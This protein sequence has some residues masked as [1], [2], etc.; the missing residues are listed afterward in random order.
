MA[1]TSL[2]ENLLEIGRRVLSEQDLDQVLSVA[3]DGAIEIS[4]AERGIILLFDHSGKIRFQTARN[5]EKEE[6]NQP[7]YEISRT[8]INKVRAEKTPLYLK[9]AREDPEFQASQS[10]IKLKILSVICLPLMHEGHVFGEVYLDNRTVRGAFKPESFLFAQKFADFISVAAHHALERLQLDS[11]VHALQKELREKFHFEAV[12]GTHP[13]IVEILDLIAQIADTDAT[14]LLQGE[15]GTGKELIA[16][17]LHT[18]SRRCNKPFVPINCGALPENLLESELFGHVRGAFTGATE[19]KSGWFERA[20]GGTI[21]L[22]EVAEMSPAMQVKLLRILQTGEFS[23]VGSTNIHQCDVRIV[24]A[25]NQKLERLIKQ[26][27]FR[28]DLYYRL[29]V[30]GIDIPPLRERKS[31]ISLLA[32]HFIKIFGNKYNKKNLR[33][34]D[35]AKAH[36]FMYDFPGNIRELENIIQRATILAKGDV[37]ETHHLPVNISP[38]EEGDSEE[39]KAI[40]FKSAKQRLVQKFEREFII[41][42]LMKSKGNISRAAKQS[43]MDVKNFYTK[44]KKYGVDAKVFSEE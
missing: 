5:L 44:M 6:L 22:D 23:P 26:G 27:K 42:R 10:V 16:R 2:F 37:V 29:K 11:N 20:Y 33:L 17:A 28:E 43:G 31:D 40:T 18:N 8:I 24:A 15:S 41:D 14:V 21:F 3:M 39:G 36:L 32:E 12:L 7:K 34:S 30:I 1:E 25:T 19:N 4:G 13:A 35:K 38:Y 9:N